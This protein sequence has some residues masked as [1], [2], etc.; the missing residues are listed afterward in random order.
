VPSKAGLIYEVLASL[1]ISSLVCVSDLAN[2]LISSLE[3]DGQTVPSPFGGGVLTLGWRQGS[4]ARLLIHAT[5]ISCGRSAVPHSTHQWRR[6]SPIDTTLFLNMWI[7]SEN[8]HAGVESEK[9]A[10]GAV[11]GK[12]MVSGSRN[13]VG[14]RGLET[15]LAGRVGVCAGGL[16]VVGR[17]SDRGG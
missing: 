13:L 17:R 4:S 6:A 10:L 16:L 3:L 5:T 2:S 12:G 7:G 1:E 11:G 15:L 14:R 8:A 9:G